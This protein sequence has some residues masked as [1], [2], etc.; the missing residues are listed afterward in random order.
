MR[1]SKSLFSLIFA[2]ISGAP[3]LADW[4][5]GLWQSTPDR[6]GLVVH[7]RT[8]PCGSAICGRVERAKDRFGYD[9]PSSVV[10]RRMLL[11]MQAQPDGSYLGRVWEP[12]G[13]RILTAR[14]QVTGNVM[15]FE[16]C[17]GNSCRNV[18]WTRVR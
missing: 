16:H 2:L 18:A 11:D 6:S 12:Q 3:A 9:T 13:N 4:P 14:M 5:V 15:R 8:K 17:D 7:V 10:G 1:F